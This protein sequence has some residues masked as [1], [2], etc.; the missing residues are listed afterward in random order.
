MIELVEVLI[1]MGFTIIMVSLI[2]IAIRKSIK[3]DEETH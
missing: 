3:D 2:V 1:Y